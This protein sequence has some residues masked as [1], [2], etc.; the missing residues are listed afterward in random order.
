MADED[1]VIENEDTESEVSVE[2][3]EQEAS[4]DAVVEVTGQEAATED[5]F[6]KASNATQKRI[7]QLTKKMRQAER[8]REEALRYAGQVQQ[9]STN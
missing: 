2:V 5:E 3:E 6:E 7:N 1:L 9:E 8:E 4:D